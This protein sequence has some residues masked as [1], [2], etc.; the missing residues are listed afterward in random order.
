MVCALPLLVKIYLRAHVLVAVALFML[1]LGQNHACS[2]GKLL[3]RV[4][5]STN[6]TNE[7]TGAGHNF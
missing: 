1:Y 2:L 6:F 3:N 5:E 7:N 4:L